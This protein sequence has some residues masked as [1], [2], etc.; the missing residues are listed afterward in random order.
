MNKSIV[1][2]LSFVLSGVF[3]S[4]QDFE[5]KVPQDFDK[6][7]KEIPHG[8][9]DTIQYSSVTVGTTRKALVY[10]PPGLKK[11]IKYFFIRAKQ[12]SA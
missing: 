5:K 12:V 7:K 6:E 4:A 11:G 1:L 10:T 3:I 9:I 8:T 2:A